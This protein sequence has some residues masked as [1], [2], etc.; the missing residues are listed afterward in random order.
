M[1]AER[2]RVGSE[3]DREEG[4]VCRVCREQMLKIR[5]YCALLNGCW[6]PRECPCGQDRFARVLLYFYKPE[7]VRTVRARRLNK[8]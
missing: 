6:I 4:R 8:D 2:G 1:A 3:E 5:G 7:A